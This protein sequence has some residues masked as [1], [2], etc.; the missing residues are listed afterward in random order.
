MPWEIKLL[1]TAILLFLYPFLK[2]F[3]RSKFPYKNTRNILKDTFHCNF[4][5]HNFLLLL[6]SIVICR[7]YIIT[8]EQTI[9]YLFQLVSPY[10]CTILIL[11][12]I[13]VL[14]SLKIIAS[15]IVELSV[16]WHVWL[17]YSNNTAATSK[18]DSGSSFEKTTLII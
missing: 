10:I 11:D 4:S 3:S 14:G 9:V 18:I 15:N 8:N 7:Y 2:V 1:I 12:N 13:A 5:L 6:F 16:N 17:T